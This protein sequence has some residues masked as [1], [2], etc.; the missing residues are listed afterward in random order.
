MYI[1]FCLRAIRLSVMHINT[2]SQELIPGTCTN[3]IVK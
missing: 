3:I 2:N 1:Y